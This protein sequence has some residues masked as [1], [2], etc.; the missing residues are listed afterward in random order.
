VLPTPVGEGGPGIGDILVAQTGFDNG[1]IFLLPGRAWTAGATQVL[2]QYL[3][4]PTAE[5]LRSLRLRQELTGQ[6][7][8]SVFA[9]D[10]QGGVDATGDGVPDV[11]AGAS[12]RTLSAGRDGKSIYLF[13]GAALADLVGTD[14]RVDIGANPLVGGSWRGANGWV[15]RSDFPGRFGS[16]RLLPGFTGMSFGDPAFTPPHLMHANTNSRTLL[17]RANHQNADEDYEL[18]LFPVG[19]G[20]AVNR[21]TAGD[22]SIGGWLTGG[23]DF[24]G[25]GAVDIVTGTNFSEVLIIR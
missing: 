5:D 20:T 21:F 9:V 25:D 14:V 23:F 12:N 18:G 17:F 3:T 8:N 11:L 10:F 13:D 24:T 1:R 4:T 6:E 2:T 16:A 7:T 22:I 15:F 19:D